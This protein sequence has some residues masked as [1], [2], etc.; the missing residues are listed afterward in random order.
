M[1]DREEASAI[2]R[3]AWLEVQR[4]ELEEQEAAL[5]QEIGRLEC[6]L[7]VMYGVLGLCQQCYKFPQVSSVSGHCGS[8]VRANFSKFAGIVCFFG[9]CPDC[10]SPQMLQG[11]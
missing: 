5:A 1:R 8:C 7:V 10:L 9:R 2:E 3:G 4:R 11:S 6:A